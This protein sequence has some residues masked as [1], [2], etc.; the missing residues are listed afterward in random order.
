MICKSNILIIRKCY[1]TLLSLLPPSCMVVP[2]SELVSIYTST[3]TFNLKLSQIDR[4]PANVAIDVNSDIIRRRINSRST[5]IVSKASSIPYHKR[6]EINND[7]PD[8]EFIDS[9][10]SFQL[11]Y[12]GDD[13]VGNLVRKVTDTGCIGI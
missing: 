4:I 9:I 2:S 3:S 8:K 12:K 6:M 7:L 5:S 13:K 1:Y 10:N 11:S